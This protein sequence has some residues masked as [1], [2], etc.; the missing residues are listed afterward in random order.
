MAEA[1]E[2]AH[3]PPWTE[4]E[5]RRYLT[6][7]ILAF[8]FATARCNDCRQERL[9]AFSCKGRCVCPSCTNRRVAEVAA[10]L[11]DSVVP[12]EP[13]RQWVLSVP[14]RLRPSPMRDSEP[15]S[16]VLRILLRA[17]RSELQASI[18]G[19]LPG[20]VRLGA[21]SFLHR[22][23]SALNPHPHFH[24][25]VTDGLFAREGDADDPPL[26]FHPAVTLDAERARALTPILQSGHEPSDEGGRHARRGGPHPRDRSGRRGPGRRD[27]PRPGRH[28]RHARDRGESCDGTGSAARFRSTS[29]SRTPPP[30]SRSAT[31][32]HV[33]I[34]PDIGPIRRAPRADRRREAT[35]LICARSPQVKSTQAPGPRRRPGREVRE[36]SD[37]EDPEDRLAQA[38]RVDVLDRVRSLR[39]EPLRPVRLH[40]RAHGRLEL[41]RA[42]LTVVADPRRAVDEHHA[43]PAMGVDGLLRPGWDRH[44]HYA[45]PLV[46]EQHAVR[47]GSGRRGVERGRPGPGIIAH[48][49]GP[50]RAPSARHSAGGRRTLARVGPASA[51]A[52]LMASTESDAA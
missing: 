27:G 10:H 18:R 30:A 16:A 47:V 9:V 42:V 23:G 40:R 24:L 34:G 21:V 25:A 52:T 5:F 36:N 8:G 33:S 12:A 29:P 46:L 28:D 50:V 44:L 2:V 49:A 37:I 35:V 31:S 51:N 14:K 17:V 39:F 4:H 45:H 11:S 26:R 22:F 6:C 3:L 43:P 48:S 41:E 7:G 15:A 19:P 38:H 13:M 32:V 1:D 20:D